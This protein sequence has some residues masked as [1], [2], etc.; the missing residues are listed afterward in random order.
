M[1][2]LPNVTTASPAPSLSMPLAKATRRRCPPQPSRKEMLQ[3]IRD[4]VVWHLGGA[5]WVK[6]NIKQVYGHAMLTE[7]SDAEIAAVYAKAVA[8]NA[9]LT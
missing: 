1:Q 4:L 3:A 7:L 6:A 8:D 2:G 9:V 5:T